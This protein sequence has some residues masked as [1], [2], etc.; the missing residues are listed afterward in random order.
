MV[1]QNGGVKTIH[2]IADEQVPELRT[3]NMSVSKLKKG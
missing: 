3:F 2:Q 1:N